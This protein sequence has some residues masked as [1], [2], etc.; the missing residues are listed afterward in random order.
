[1]QHFSNKS[2]VC[3]MADGRWPLV[4]MSWLLG[5]T[6]GGNL[7]RPVSP[8]STKSVAPRDR[9]IVWIALPASLGRWRSR[10][11]SIGPAG[12]RLRYACNLLKLSS[13]LI[14]LFVLDSLFVCPFVGDGGE[15][16][17]NQ[18]KYTLKFHKFISCKN[19]IQLHIRYNL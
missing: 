17:R 7:P 9:N 10:R 6:G 13:K 3:R 8:F 15:K 1:M 14:L 18:F 4:V 12:H 19:S 11:P 16:N 2:G 5:G